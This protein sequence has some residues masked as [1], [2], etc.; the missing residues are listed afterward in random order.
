MQ[1]KYTRHY[2]DHKIVH[3]DGPTKIENLEKCTLITT[4]A[5]RNSNRAASNGVSFLV[6]SDSEKSLAG[7]KPINKK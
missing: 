3:D 1:I 2:V 7:I 5:W 4:S 6:D